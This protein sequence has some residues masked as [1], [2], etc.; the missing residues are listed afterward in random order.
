MAKIEDTIDKLEG[1]DE[2]ETATSEADDEQSESSEEES[3]VDWPTLSAALS[4]RI[5]YNDLSSVDSSVHDW[6][7]V[8]LSVHDSSFVD[9]SALMPF[10]RFACC[11]PPPAQVE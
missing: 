11:A 4:T 2:S 10:A 9:L 6:S 7:F 8:D 5:K 1:E 3:S